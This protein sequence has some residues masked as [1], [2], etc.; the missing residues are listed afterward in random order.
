VKCDHRTSFSHGRGHRLRRGAGGDQA[1]SLFPFSALLL[2]R[3]GSRFKRHRIT[4][5]RRAEIPTLCGTSQ[6][7][8]R[9]TAA[10]PF[11]RNVALGTTD[12]ISPHHDLRRRNRSAH[13]ASWSARRSLPR[14][15]L[16]GRLVAPS[17]L[18][19]HSL[20]DLL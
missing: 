15:R 20:I 17:G 5:G 11:R 7:K 18:L 1:V 12:Y 4:S 19:S 6:S 13:L 3:H 16:A 9:L 10:A 14:R 8:L 2:L